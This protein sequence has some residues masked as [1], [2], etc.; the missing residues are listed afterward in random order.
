MVGHTARIGASLAALSL[1]LGLGGVAGAGRAGADATA[2]PTQLV[3]VDAHIGN[4]SLTE[5]TRQNPIVI[6]PQNKQTLSMTVRNQSNTTANIR[7]LRLTG[8]LIGIHFVNYQASVNQDIAPGATQTIS[9]PGDFFDVDSAATGYV[10]ADMQL[11]NQ[12]RSLLASQ[13]FV[14]DVDGK[15]ASSVGFLLLQVTLFAVIS[16]AD[17]FYGL[18]RRR[19]PRNRFMR[20]VLFA[21]ATSSTVMAVVIAA[22]VF[23]VALFGAAVWL[24]AVLIAA[25][26]GFILGYTSPG[27]V[28]RTSREDADD[29]VIDLVA[30]DAVARASGQFEPGAT[31]TG[32][33]SHA[34]GDH[35]SAMASHASGDH[36]GAMASHASGD[37]T[38]IAAIAHASGDHSDVAARLA[39]EAHE[40][41][42][43]EPI[44]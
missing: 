34:S 39:N 38:D 3:V 29:R 12:D 14:A 9:V 31:T 10:N 41:G 18:S 5:G 43:H 25:A 6:S 15:L 2:A 7:F 42:S 37:H 27:R 32:S 8:A 40:S 24:P 1:L 30:A 21:L 19:L 28:V 4:R 13:R 11:V 16:L 23:R 33:M 36:T 44:E 22:A 20:G 35:S 26:V 17:V